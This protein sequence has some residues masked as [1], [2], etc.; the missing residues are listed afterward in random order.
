MESASRRSGPPPWPRSR[1]AGTGAGTDIAPTIVFLMSDDSA[2]Y[3]GAEIVIDGGLSAHV[4]HKGIAD[5]TRPPAGPLHEAVAVRHA[6]GSRGGRRGDTAYL[7]SHSVGDLVRL[8][9]ERALEIGS[10]AVQGSRCDRDAPGAALPPASIRDF[11]TFE[12]H[13]EGVRQAASTTPSGVPEAWYDAPTFYFTNPHALYGPGAADSSPGLVAGRWTSSWRWLRGA[14]PRRL[15]ASE[16]RPRSR[17]SATRS[18]TT[19]PPAISSPARCRSGL[20][21]AKGKDFATSFGPWIVTADEL[22]GVA[23]PRLPGLRQRRADRSRQPGEHAL[24]VRPDDRLR[25]SGL[26]GA[27]RR[28]ARLGHDGRRRLPCGTVGP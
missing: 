16:R 9:L 14:R 10:G 1:W 28:P 25:L 15:V 11:V 6:A 3:N 27:G 22:P 24:V 20:G 18:S 7:L 21:P 5:A 23:R 17:S 8:G 26:G 19:G 2:Y 4:S 13:V 12:S